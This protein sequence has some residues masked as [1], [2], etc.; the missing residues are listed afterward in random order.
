MILRRDV[1]QALADP[2]RRAILFLLASQTI[3]A[4]AIADHF[5]NARSTISKHIQIL[6]E[7]GLVESNQQGREIYYQLK[8]ERMKEIDLWLDQLKRIWEDRFDNLDKY[9]EKIQKNRP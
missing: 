7:C 8:F 4:G 9:L 2:T 3:T 6:T 1:F 5:D